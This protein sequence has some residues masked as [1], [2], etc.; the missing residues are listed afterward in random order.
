MA[1]TGSDGEAQ[2]GRPRNPA[3]DRKLFAEFAAG[4]TGRGFLNV[5]KLAER[6]PEQGGFLELIEGFGK[7]YA[8][9]V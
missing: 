8:R 2:A 1:P 4:D 9:P 7:R 5:Q 3:K 6:G